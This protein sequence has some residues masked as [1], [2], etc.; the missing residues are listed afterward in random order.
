MLYKKL[1]FQDFCDEFQRKGRDGNYSYEAKRLIFDYLNDSEDNV[2]L[3]VIAI[4]C[5]FVE[6]SVQ[7]SHDDDID[8]LVDCLN[9][10]TTVIGVT[11]ASI[12]YFNY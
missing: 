10:H 12:V 6:A 5:D 4:C 11:D 7:D 8:N 3:D 2:Q 1:T 9:D